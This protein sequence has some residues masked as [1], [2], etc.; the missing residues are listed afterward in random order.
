MADLPLPGTST[1]RGRRTS[2]P[3]VLPGRHALWAAA[4]WAGTTAESGRPFAGSAPPPCWTW[5]GRSSL[6]WRRRGAGL[7]HRCAVAGSQSRSSAPSTFLTGS[8]PW[9]AGA[10][11]A[12]GSLWCRDGGASARARPAANAR[13]QA[14]GRPA[15]GTGAN[16]ACSRLSTQRRS[17]PGPATALSPRRPAA[18][19]CCGQAGGAA[20]RAGAGRANSV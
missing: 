8:A 3:G 6:G 2:A 5:S 11:S 12:P 15:R 14:S 20:V 18:W 16:V 13:G 9:R 10:E 4:L 17:R 1:L 19:G 7:P